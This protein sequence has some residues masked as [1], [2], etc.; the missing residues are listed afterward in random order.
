VKFVTYT[1]KIP[2]QGEK[3]KKKKKQMKEGVVYFQ[4]NK[5]RRGRG[6]GKGRKK[7]SRLL[8]VKESS[9]AQERWRN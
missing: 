6:T 7:L 8:Q 4:M 9:I 3:E 5:G 2:C 1:G